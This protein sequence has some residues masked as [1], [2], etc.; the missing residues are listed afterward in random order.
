MSVAKSGADGSIYHGIGLR[1]SCI[2]A[3][4]GLNFSDRLLRGVVRARVDV[5]ERLTRLD[6]RAL[7]DKSSKTHCEIDR[8]RRPPPP[9]AEAHHGEADT[10]TID[11]ADVT[12]F[13]RRHR[14]YDWR[15]R[16]MPLRMIDEIGGAAKRG[17][18]AREAF[19]RRPA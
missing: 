8:I 18:H 16:K 2:D 9:A 10:T 4:C 17:N 19:R 12:R 13:Q 5:R 11:A 14:Q 7:S 3:I 15:L 6:F 1:C